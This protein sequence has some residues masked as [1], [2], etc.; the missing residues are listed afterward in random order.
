MEY[1]ILSPFPT[2]V[3]PS[4]D[5]DDAS[6]DD[7]GLQ[8]VNE[9]A[10][11]LSEMQLASIEEWEV[12]CQEYFEED[13]EF[14]LVLIGNDVKTFDF[15]TR[16]LPRF[17]MTLAESG[18]Q[19]P[20]LILFEPVGYQIDDELLVECND[21][22]LHSGNR[23]WGGNLTASISE[24]SRIQRLELELDCTE[25]NFPDSALTVLEHM[26]PMFLMLQAVSA[27]GMTPAGALWD[28]N[29]TVLKGDARSCGGRVAG[30]LKLPGRPFDQ[31]KIDPLRH[32]FD[33]PS[34]PDLSV[35]K[36]GSH[37][38]FIMTTPSLPSLE[39]YVAIDCEMV[40][41]R[42]S[43]ALARIG[44]VD[45]S[46]GLVLDSYV[47]VNPQNVVDYRTKSSGIRPS[48]LEGAPTF[49]QIVP[50]IK[51]LL[52]GKIVVG[53][54]LFN[55]L[56]AIQHRHPY[57]DF[58]DTALYYPLR[59]L[60]GVNREGEYPSLKSLAAKVL[61]REIHNGFGHDPAEDARATM[62]IFMSVR[63]EYE[64]SLS[65]EDVVSGIPA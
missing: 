11:S 18:L 17:F 14:Y 32:L 50:K 41:C 10:D 24:E 42:S 20:D 54:A 40:G 3:P 52:E 15:P 33:R 2:A 36:H 7:R 51:S 16:I 1:L 6:E 64:I 63:E 46:G 53:H 62:A 37:R 57:E 38:Q 58:R 8:V 56:K 49:E 35:V 44:M 27:H 26:E 65:K 21:I 19:T 48:D 31:R 5:S 25:L 30:G 28:D 23:S 61:G 4:P 55:D 43:Q 13:G 34:Y 45:H 59:R 60:V 22:S 29:Q 39:N 47:Y 9:F 12:F